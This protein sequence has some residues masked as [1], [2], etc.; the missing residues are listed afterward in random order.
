MFLYRVNQLEDAESASLVLM[1]DWQE[2]EK[3]HSKVTGLI[4]RTDDPDNDNQLSFFMS[5]YKVVGSG[6][7]KI[8]F[9]TYHFPDAQAANFKGTR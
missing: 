4:Q 8:L 2:G 7:Q 1:A 6:K 5:N 9:C 3:R